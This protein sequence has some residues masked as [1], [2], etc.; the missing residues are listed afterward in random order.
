MSQ[1]YQVEME[2][3]IC[4]AR[5][6]L[7]PDDERR[8]Q[9][10][11]TRPIHWENLRRLAEYHKM[12]PLLFHHLSRHVTE[13]IPAEWMAQLR[14]AAHGHVVWNYHQLENLR[15]LIVRLEAHDIPVIPYKGVA[16][17][18]RLYG[19]LELRHTGDLDIIVPPAAYA[20]AKALLEAEGLR[21][22]YPMTAAEEVQ[23]VREYGELSLWSE[24]RNLVLE[25]H[26]G[27]SPRYFSFPLAAMNLWAESEWQEFNGCRWRMPS[28][29]DT[30]ILLCVHGA[31]H[32]WS[33]LKWISDI[34]ELMRTPQRINWEQVLMRARVLRSERMVLVGLWL[35][36]Q[37]LAAPLPV[38]VQQRIAQSFI[39]K[40]LVASII[41]R[42]QRGKKQPATLAIM[43][44][45]LLIR[46]HW[47][48]QWKYRTI[49]SLSLRR[50][51]QRACNDA[52]ASFFRTFLRPARLVKLFAQIAV[53]EW[54]AT[55]S[56]SSIVRSNAA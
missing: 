25:L 13:A 9:A 47:Q 56:T 32:A 29:E 43:P 31:I 5:A 50:N 55:K 12:I 3:L 33:T 46:E 18:L 40:R 1:S 26:W 8:L 21:C 2:L 44:F 39:V 6:Q 52:E 42:L 53:R 17:S 28:D 35:A 45:H 16:L 7:T 48:D 23:L 36:H 22:P 24:E 14:Q 38:Q 27:I 54:R 11:L 51:W 4:C 20:P 49:L 30:L 19:G 34:A 10:L 41:T 37:L 15:H